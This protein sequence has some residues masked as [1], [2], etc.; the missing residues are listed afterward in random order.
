MVMCVA[1]VAVLVAQHLS[2]ERHGL[3]RERD[4]LVVPAGLA[5]HEREIVEGRRHVGMLVPERLAL[6]G[7]RFAQHT[8]RP[9]QVRRGSAAPAPAR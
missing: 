4:R 5:E 8:S 6:D 3:T 7:Q 9:R 2:I 1:R